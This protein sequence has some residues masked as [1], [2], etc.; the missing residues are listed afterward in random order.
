MADRQIIFHKTLN[1]INDQLSSDNRN[2][3]C[4]LMESDV[5]KY[6]LDEVR[7]NN[8][9]PMHDVFRV[10]MEREKISTTD[11]NYLVERLKTIQRID[12]VRYIEKQMP[13]EQTQSSTLFQ[14]HDP[15]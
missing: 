11:L 10:L 3:L 6:M 13:T 2:M 4:F 5:P 1:H 15:Q 9:V 14:R 12:L 8:R 7:H